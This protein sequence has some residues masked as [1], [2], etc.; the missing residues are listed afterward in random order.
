MYDA[1]VP[2]LTAFVL[3]GGKSTRMGVDKAFLEF[4]G[5]TLL[6]RALHNLRRLTSEVMIV[7]ER[8]KFA[9][10][11]SVVEDVFHNRGPLGGIHAGLATSATDLN[12]MMA[13]DMPFMELG[14]LRYLLKHAEATDAVVVVPR[15]QG[16]LQPLCAIYRKFLQAAAERSLLREDNKIDVLFQHVKTTVIE[17]DD[18]IASGFS[19]AIFDN[20]N[21]PTEFEQAKSRHT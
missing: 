6:D 18:I 7:G 2:E 12:L 14:F 13:V 11:G 15:V 5:K 4:D 19:P 8:N 9:Q 17:E 16:R 1:A 20:L 10:F 3:A 21:T